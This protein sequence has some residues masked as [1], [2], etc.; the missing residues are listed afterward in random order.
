MS[1]TANGSCPG[2]CLLVGLPRSYGPPCV[3]P[4]EWALYAYG[5]GKEHCFALEDHQVVFAAPEFVSE[6]IK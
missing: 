4:V 2:Y 1:T 6:T 3:L 5:P